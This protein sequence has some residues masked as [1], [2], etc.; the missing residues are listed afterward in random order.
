MGEHIFPS[1]SH[2]PHE[3]NPAPMPSGVLEA[4]E[5]Q[6]G[7]AVTAYLTSV[8]YGEGEV[9]LTGIIFGDERK[10]FVN[11]TKIFTSIILGTQEI[12]GYLVVHTLSSSYVVCEWAEDKAKE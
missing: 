5:I 1:L 4:M 7:L 12:Q 11:G 10:R 2:R 9:Y 8:Q 6:F 3:S